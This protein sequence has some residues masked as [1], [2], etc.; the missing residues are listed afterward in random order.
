MR[1]A[2]LLV[3]AVSVGAL[4][5]GLFSLTRLD[6]E[7]VA[8]ARAARVVADAGAEP[9]AAHPAPATPPKPI[10]A[11]GACGAA[12]EA[13][14]ALIAAVPSGALLD[15]EQNVQLTAGLARLDAD[16]DAPS[17][18]AFRDRELVPWLTYAPPAP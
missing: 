17:A 18:Q 16:C 4:A 6:R 3:I 11:S 8:P 7:D 10:P 12:M 14:R 2:W 13:L 5:T 15:E 1:R 9:I